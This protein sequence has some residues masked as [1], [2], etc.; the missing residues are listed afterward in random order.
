MIDAVAESDQI[1][2]RDRRQRL[3]PRLKSRH[4]EYQRLHPERTVTLAGFT[5]ELVE[6]AL[7]SPD[8]QARLGLSP[9]KR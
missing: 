8:V 6:V 7:Q 2:I 1:S 9:A 4:E 3:I 5:R